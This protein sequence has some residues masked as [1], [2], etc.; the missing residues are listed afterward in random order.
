MKILGLVEHPDHVC[1]RYRL[2]ALQP[3]LKQA[4]HELD[5]RAIPDGFWARMKLW[6]RTREVD[7]VIVLRR[8]MSCWHVFHLRRNA[9]RLVYDFDD[10]VFQRDSYSGK[11]FQSVVRRRRFIRML[12]AAD[13][14]FAG[15]D[16]L[17]EEACRFVPEEQVQV[18]P[19][20]V[21]TN[22]YP[23]A[24][25]RLKGK[26]VLLAWIGSR[27]TLQGLT[28]TSKLW[29]HLARKVPGIAMKVICDEFPIFETMKVLPTPWSH[30]TEKMELATADIGVSWVPDDPWSRGKCG[31]KILQYM[32]AGLPVIANPVGV[33]CELVRHGET[34]LLAS[35][36][37][38][39]TASVAKLANDPD[40]RQRLGRAGRRWVELDYSVA[41]LASRWLHGIEPKP[42]PLRLAA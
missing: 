14:I 6:R 17:K 1:C 22:D 8:L 12:H 37:E 32:A 23:I 21:E 16:F 28:K 11:P 27:S 42:Q 38:E 2:T 5:I 26:G 10:A 4:G 13:R 36:V 24:E 41:S 25:H 20:C 18:M 19:T 31:L 7:L 15:N 35:T 39:W 3:H 33:Q 9:R 29:N 34:G 30:K 40:F